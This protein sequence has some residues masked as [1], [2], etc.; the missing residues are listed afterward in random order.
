MSHVLVDQPFEKHQTAYLEG[1]FAASPAGSRAVPFAGHLPGGQITS[2]PSSGVPNLAL[3]PQAPPTEPAL[4]G[5]PVADL[6]EQELWKLER[7]GLDVWD[8]MLRHAEE[9]KFPDKKHTFLFRYHGLFY[10]AP[11]Q[12]SFMLRCRIPS[13]VLTS[14][15]LHGLADIA[16]LWAGDAPTSRPGRTS[17]SARSRPGTSSRC[18]PG[19]RSSASPPGGL[20]S[21]TCA[22]SPPRPR[23]AS[24]PP[25]S[26]TRCP[27]PRRSITTSSIIATSMACRA[28]STSP[29][30]AA[31]PSA[32]W[33]TRTT[34][35]SSP[36][37]WTRGAGAAVR[38]RARAR[39][40]LPRAPGGHHRHEQFAA[41]AGVLVKPG[42]P[43]LSR[44]RSSASS[45]STAT[46]RTARRRGSNTSSTAGA[47]RSSCRGRGEARLPAHP[48]PC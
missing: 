11:A 19:S 48:S 25:S 12:D 1:Y 8:E 34:S 5:T 35:A 16:A 37:A 18:S 43:S 38:R 27:S 7:H 46:A 20:G 10:V 6:T 17:R 30:T 28:S 2:A 33:P 4:H 44:R 22:T 47:W 23:P 45:S 13:G 3:A 31:A 32:P 9:E 29:S 41:D 36:C 21:I 42:M 40:L 24:T 26:S 14:A 39:H 15:Q